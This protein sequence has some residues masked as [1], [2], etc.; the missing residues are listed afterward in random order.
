MIIDEALTHARDHSEIYVILSDYFR[1]LPR[2]ESTARTPSS[3]VLKDAVRACDLALQR[4][5]SLK[6]RSNDMSATF[7][8]KATSLDAELVQ[9][10]RETE[11]RVSGVR[12]FTLHIGIA[13]AP[14]LAAQRAQHV[15]SCAFLSACNPHSQPLDAASNL[16]LHL[17]LGRELRGR[18]LQ[19][20]EGVGEHPSNG[21]PAEPGYLVFGLTLEA[22]KT[23]AQRHEQN[24]LVWAG[25]DATPQLILLR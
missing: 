18:S 6:S 11:Y 5:Q 15:D 23:L 13:S 20:R 9:A 24:A 21:W 2:E 12:P 8:P 10:Y 16:T 17:A 7:C 1:K 25:G 14:L 19:I 4:L 22:A 3:G